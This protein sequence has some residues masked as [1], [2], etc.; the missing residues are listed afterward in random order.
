MEWLAKFFESGFGASTTLG[1]AAFAMLIIVALV[2]LVVA[3]TNSSPA[4]VFLVAIV[5]IVGLVIFNQFYPLPR[6]ES[7]VTALVKLQPT[8]PNVHAISLITRGQQSF[9]A[10]KDTTNH[11]V[12]TYSFSV[13]HDVAREL[14]QS[15]FNINYTTER[16]HPIRFLALKQ[17]CRIISTCC[18]ILR[19]T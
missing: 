2:A 9:S 16:D 12:D 1:L 19:S 6:P 11:R 10:T 14:T 17:N 3:L 7:D 15:C 4:F 18:S 5:C 8:N 13:P